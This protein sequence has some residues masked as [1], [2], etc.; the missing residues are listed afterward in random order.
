MN[1]RIV[2]RPVKGMPMS[3]EKPNVDEMERQTEAMPQKARLV[4]VK[5]RSRTK[6]ASTTKMQ[7]TNTATAMKGASPP[8]LSPMA[9]SMEVGI[10][11]KTRVCARESGNAAGVSRSSI[12]KVASSTSAVLTS[13]AMVVACRGGGAR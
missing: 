4:R 3:T 2:L 5:T 7:M 10:S 13:G 1:G 6:S 11:K 12:A 8:M 9:L